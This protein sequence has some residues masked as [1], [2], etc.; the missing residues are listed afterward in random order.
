VQGTNLYKE[1]LTIHN[2]TYHDSQVIKTPE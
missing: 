1:R 2:K